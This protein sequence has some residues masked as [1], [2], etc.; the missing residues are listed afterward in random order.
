MCS[1]SSS[2][3]FAAMVAHVFGLSMF[4]HP[5]NEKALTLVYPDGTRGT[6]DMTNQGRFDMAAAHIIKVRDRKIHE[7]ETVLPFDSKNGWSDFLR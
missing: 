2:V 1:R 5:M 6:R 3:Y 7:I 4:H